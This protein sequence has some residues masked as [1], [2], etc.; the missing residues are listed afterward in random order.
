LPD[1]PWCVAPRLRFERLFATIPQVGM[2]RA[3]RPLALSIVALVFATL[4]FADPLED[5]PYRILKGAERFSIGGVGYAGS[6]SREE[7][8]FRVVWH[9][10]SAS[11][12]FRRLISE[13]TIAGRLYAL[14]GLRHLD[15]PSFQAELRRYLRSDA[16]VE[17]WSGCLVHR[18]PAAEVAADIERGDY[19]GR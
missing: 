7:R 12:D 11:D 4:A 5:Q 6:L 15:A 1:G 2:C 3:A 18:Q 16:A 9:R 17:T 19:D 10:S 14:L 8:A 13:A